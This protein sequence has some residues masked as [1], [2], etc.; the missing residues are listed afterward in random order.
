MMHP[1]DS[2]EICMHG[3]LTCGTYTNRATQIAVWAT[4]H[5]CRKEIMYDARKKVGLC[6]MGKT[7]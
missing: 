5:V 3:G 2:I 4:H 1:E 7:H 6:G